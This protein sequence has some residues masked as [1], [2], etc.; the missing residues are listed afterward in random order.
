M[1]VRNQAM[2]TVSPTERCMNKITFVFICQADFFEYEVYFFNCY[3]T[4][5]INDGFRFVVENP[6]V[7]GIYRGVVTVA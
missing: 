1:V 2:S 4:K 7:V 6:F 3:R 5:P